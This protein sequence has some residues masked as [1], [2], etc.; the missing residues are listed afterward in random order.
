MDMQAWAPQKTEF[1]PFLSYLAKEL[2]I[3]FIIII[4]FYS[5]ELSNTF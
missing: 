5:T 2:Y 1:G 3:F 4:I